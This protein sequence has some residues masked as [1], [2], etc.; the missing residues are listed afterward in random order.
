MTTD[1]ELSW[2]VERYRVLVRQFASLVTQGAEV[3][4]LRSKF[5]QIK[6]EH[7]RYLVLKFAAQSQEYAR[8]ACV[9]MRFKAAH[10]D[11]QTMED[12]LKKKGVLLRVEAVG[13]PIHGT[14]RYLVT[15][16]DKAELQQEKRMTPTWRIIALVTVGLLFP[17]KGVLLGLY[18]AGYL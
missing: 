13:I 14:E 15:R 4:V 8:S 18:L 11:M 10:A 17:V 12:E 9:R 7:D 2:S 3:T 6:A 1:T 16:C 5:Q